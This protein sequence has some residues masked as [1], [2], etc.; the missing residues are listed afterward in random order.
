MIFQSGH[1][2]LWEMDRKEGRVPNNWCFQ[3]VVLEK[4]P[5]SL[6]DSKEIK[7][8]NFKGNQPWILIG[9]TDA[10]AETVVF[11]SSDANSWLIGKVPDAGKDWRQKNKRASEDE[12]AGWHYKFREMVRDREACSPWDHKESD[13]T[14]WLNNNKKNYKTPKKVYHCILILQVCPCI[15]SISTT[16]ELDRKANSWT[17]P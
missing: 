13:T 9:R 6:L 3:T 7:P 15:N 16:W 8:V 2:W 10:E 4:I 14:G 17:I 11:W 12:M 1:I 5:E